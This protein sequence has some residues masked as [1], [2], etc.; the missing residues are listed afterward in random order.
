MAA[1]PQLELP[2]NGRRVL[3][4][5]RTSGAHLGRNYGGTRIDKS[6][7][8]CLTLL[9]QQSVATVMGSAFG[10]EGYVRISFATSLE[11]LTAGFDRIEAFLRSAA[12]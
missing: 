3:C 12:V 6:A 4:V 10:A 1:I 8:W 7:Q 11:T 9:E 2:R 5:R